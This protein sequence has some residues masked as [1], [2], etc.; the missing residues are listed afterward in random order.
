MPLTV[1]LVSCD[2][3]ANVITWT[4]KSCT[5][6]LSSWPKEC[7]GTIN[8]AIGIMWYTSARGI[9]SPKMHVAHHFNCLDIRNVMV[10]LTIPSASCDPG[11]DAYGVTWPKKSCCTSFWFS[12]LVSLDLR[13]AFVPLMMSLVSHDQKKKS[14]S[15]LFQSSWP[16]KQNHSIDNAVSSM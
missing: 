7:N 16:N 15:M 11:A 4:K 6:F 1:A 3:D 2:A 9:T 5:S 13:N 12:C 10:P 8:D 14:C